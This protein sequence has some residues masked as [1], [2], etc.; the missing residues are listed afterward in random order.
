MMRLLKWPTYV[1]SENPQNM[2]GHL[3]TAGSGAADG[4]K[5]RFGYGVS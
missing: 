1:L 3:Q 4:E 2:A 5:L